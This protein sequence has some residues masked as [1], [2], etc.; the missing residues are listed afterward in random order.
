MLYAGQMLS[1]LYDTYKRFLT[2]AYLYMDLT[3]FHINIIRLE[4]LF[5]PFIVVI[6]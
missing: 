6:L 3:V 2:Q 1:H 4:Q 5:H